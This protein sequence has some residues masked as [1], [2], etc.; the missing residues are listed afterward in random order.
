VN[1]PADWLDAW[2]GDWG[3]YCTWRREDGRASKVNNFVGG[4]CEPRRYRTRAEAEREAAWYRVNGAK[5]AR[6]DARPFLDADVYALLL[7]VFERFVR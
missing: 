1:P 7:S 2:T 6:F 3:V 4:K 5:D